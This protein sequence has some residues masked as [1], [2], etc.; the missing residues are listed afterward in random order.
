MLQSNPITRSTTLLFALILAPIQAEVAGAARKARLELRYLPI[1]LPG[2]PSTILPADLDGDGSQDLV[3]V[4]AFTEWDQI[5][6]EE[7]AE[8]DGVAGLVEVLTI[9][10]SLMDR[11]ELRVFLAQGDGFRALPTLELDRSVLSL[12]SGPPVLP[13]V[14]LT[15]DG[16][17]ALRLTG[18]G[19]AMGPVLE[20]VLRNRPV[21]ARSGTFI[22]NLGF[23]HDLDGDG[24][25]DVLFPTADGA[26]AYL[27]R[28]SGLAAEPASRLMWPVLDAPKEAGQRRSSGRRLSHHHP[29]PQVRDVD[30]DGLVD[31]LLL[32]QGSG[33]ERFHVLRNLGEGRFAAPMMLG[34]EGGDEEPEDATDEC[35]D[36]DRCPPN[37]ELVYFGDLDG[38]GAAEY[39]TQEE[40]VS[41]DDGIRQE[42]KQAKQPSF[43]YRLHRSGTD[44]TMASEPYRVFQATGYSFEGSSDDDG[45]GDMHLPGGFQDLDGDGRSDLITLTL[46]FSMMQAVKILTTHR[47]SIGLDFHVWCQDSEGRFQAVQGLDLSGKFRL[48]LD[49]LRMGQM[50][51]FAGDFDA[52]GKADFLQMGRGRDV[53]IHRG[54]GGCVYPPDPDLRIR[55]KEE[56][57]DLELV[58]V[59]D[60]DGDGLTDL[61]VIQPQK[62]TEPGVTP[63]VR[64]DMY[65]SRDRQNGGGA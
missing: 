58:R 11:R 25:R 62:V 23:S 59:E 47:I 39:V 4:V 1:E 27:T 41:G 24:R 64:L 49:N 12:E 32:D 13:I 34:E 9:V 3:V 38:D 14:A 51:Q 53:T 43:R 55:L 42:M 50:S 40:L 65:L 28:D 60:F 10:P 33:W 63:P 19:D 26:A 17:S 29:L 7:S 31:L 5:G 52:D 6:I 18:E 57:K 61:I 56:P 30:G 37:T 2:A 44:L 48:D 36:E 15:D 8:I 20:P 21:L 35:A 46:D 22:P 54:R 45:D 16:I